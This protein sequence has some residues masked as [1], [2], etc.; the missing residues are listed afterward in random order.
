MRQPHRGLPRPGVRIHLFHFCVHRLDQYLPSGREVGVSFHQAHRYLLALLLK[1]KPGLAR[2]VYSL[3]DF[4]RAP[5]KRI[6]LFSLWGTPSRTVPKTQP[7]QVA[8]SLLSIERVDLRSQKEGI[9]EKNIA[10]GRAG[11]TG[12]TKRKKGCVKKKGFA[13]QRTLPY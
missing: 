6:F 10:S 5:E 13:W 9:W 7:L 4:F 2:D 8:F 11:R 1:L 12:Q 3:L